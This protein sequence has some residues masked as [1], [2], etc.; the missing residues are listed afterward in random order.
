MSEKKTRATLDAK[1]T[2]RSNPG[3]YDSLFGR[4]PLGRL[5]LFCMRM[6]SGLRAGVGI[7]K[8]L[9]TEA[10]QGSPHHRHVMQQAIDKV[11][12]GETL[13][14]A[15]GCAGNYFPPLLI[16]MISAGETSG[17]L[18]RILAHM[19]QYYQEL[20][21]A[22]RQFLGQIA[23][24]LI[25]L[26][27]AIGVICLV[28]ALR[29]FLSRGPQEGQFDSLGLGLAGAS[30]VAIFLGWVLMVA[31][32][33]F[34][35]VVAIWKNIF[36]CH[37]ILIPIILPIPVLGGVFSNTAM[38]RMSMTLSMLLNSGVDAIRSVREAFLSTGNHFYIQGMK[39]ALSN[40]QQGQSLAHSLNEAKVFPREFIAGIEVGELSGN[41]TESLEYLASVYSRRA[42]DS[43]TQLSV[44][45]ST[46]IWV[47]IAA[48]IVMFILMMVMQYVNMVNSLLN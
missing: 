20:R 47:S 6:S 24:P 37:Q 12:S 46:A 21:L 15:L 30:G 40:V 29:G 41:E 7:L 18:D 28:I 31:L 9:E 19:T 5:E 27:L 13:A 23:W 34:G 4:I 10:K 2:H 35:I 32:V 26:G 33:I 11:R 22:R 8:L 17:G 36:N 16:Q 48:L 14:K 44:L 25:Q 43:M 3:L 42:K 39:P 45:A 1:P 38:A